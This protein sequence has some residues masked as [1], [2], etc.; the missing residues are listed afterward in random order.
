MWRGL[1]PF[2]VRIAGGNALPVAV[3]AVNALSAKTTVESQEATCQSLQCSHKGRRLNSYHPVGP[4]TSSGAS[5]PRTA[6]R[7]FLGA[8]TRP[9]C[10]PVLRSAEPL[11]TEGVVCKANI[12]WCCLRKWSERVV[13]AIRGDAPSIAK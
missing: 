2:G 9:G 8:I 7:T 5:S 10:I 11:L 12:E 6:G 3:P 1:S 13:V 4:P